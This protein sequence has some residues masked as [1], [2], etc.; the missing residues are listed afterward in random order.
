VSTTR[1]F[2]RASGAVAM[3]VTRPFG[4]PST[5]PPSY[6]WM[7]VSETMPVN[8]STGAPSESST[9]MDRVWS[10]SM[11]RPVP[12]RSMSSQIA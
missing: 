4:I 8:T 2:I 7:A 6:S 10:G 9:V 5:S 3:T 12:V 11:P 1:R